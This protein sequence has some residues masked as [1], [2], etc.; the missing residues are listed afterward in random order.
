MEQA[1]TPPCRVCGAAVTYTL[2]F[3]V[4]SGFVV[5][6]YACVKHLRETEAFGLQ[7]GW[8]FLPA[9]RTTDVGAAAPVIVGAL[10]EWLRPP[11]SRR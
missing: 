10:G 6:L 5:Q 2:R 11:K 3:Q 4:R 1:T 9:G 7:N 8:E